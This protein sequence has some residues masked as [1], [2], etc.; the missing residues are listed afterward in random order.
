M[1]VEAQGVVSVGSSRSERELACRHAGG[2]VTCS[3]PRTPGGARPRGPAFPGSSSRAAGRGLRALLEWGVGDVRAEFPAMPG[4]FEAVSERAQPRDDVV[5]VRVT[6]PRFC[7][8][9]GFGLRPRA[10]FRLRLRCTAARRF[11]LLLHE[12]GAERAF[13]CVLVVGPAT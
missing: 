6:R 2:L 13:G 1:G 4:A 10:C 11:A 9:F 5:L 3:G 12:P 8:R 7:L